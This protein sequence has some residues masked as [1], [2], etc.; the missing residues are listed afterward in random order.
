VVK[1]REVMVVGVSHV[2]AVAVCVVWW[3]CLFAMCGGLS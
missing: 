1:A 2:I 3:V